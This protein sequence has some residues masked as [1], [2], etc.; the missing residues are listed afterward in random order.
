MA[1]SD[2]SV[3]VAGSPVSGSGSGSGLWDSCR[4]SWHLLVSCQLVI[5]V[6]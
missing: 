2:E 5:A 3:R 4:D 1:E 6:H